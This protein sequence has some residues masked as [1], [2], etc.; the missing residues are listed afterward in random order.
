MTVRMIVSGIRFNLAGLM[1]VL[2]SSFI[3]TIQTY[4]LSIIKRKQKYI[5]LFSQKVFIHIIKPHNFSTNQQQFSFWEIP[6][7]CQI[8]QYIYIQYIVDTE[9]DKSWDR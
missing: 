7:S 1:T 3:H 8:P 2:L 5:I 6:F 9:K 4:L